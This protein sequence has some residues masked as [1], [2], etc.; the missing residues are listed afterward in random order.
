MSNSWYHGN[1]IVS[2]NTYDG[3]TAVGGQTIENQAEGGRNQVGVVRHEGLP[4]ARGHVHP[5]G[6]AQLLALETAPP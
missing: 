3:A 4:L 6:Q 1:G 2:V 5:L